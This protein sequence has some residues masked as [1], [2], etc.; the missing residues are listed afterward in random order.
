M[1]KDVKDLGFKRSSLTEEIWRIVFIG[2]SL[3][4]VLSLVSYHPLDSPRWTSTPN[5]PPHNLVKVVGAHLSDALYFYIGWGALF[6]PAILLFC[7]LRRKEG[8]SFRRELLLRGGGT[9]LL[10]L[11]LSSLLSLPGIKGPFRIEDVNIPAGGFIGLWAG[12][13]V[14]LLFG[15]FS[16][17]LCALT[18]LVGSMVAFD[19]SL[20]HLIRT[21]K[22][23]IRVSKE[24]IVGRY[25]QR[26]RDL[27]P[28]RPVPL[29]RQATKV[30]KAEGPIIE[31]A[32]EKREEPTS[33]ELPTLTLLDEPR[34]SKERKEGVLADSRLL[35]NT[36]HEFGIDAKVLQVSQGPR[37]TRFEV[38]PAPGVRVASIMGLADDIALALATPN[39][40]IET[41]IPGKSAIGIEVP[42]KRAGI[43]CLRE[44]LESPK[45]TNSD[46][47]LLIGLGKDIS[48]Q[49]V[50]IDLQEMPHLLIAGATGSG[51]SVCINSIIVSLLYRV[52]PSEAKFMLI[53]PKR[54]E[55]GIFNGIPH[56]I[57]PVINDP[58]KSTQAM[59]WL[60]E[61]MEERYKR[62]AKMGVRDIEGYNQRAK[63]TQEIEHL[64]Y[65]IMV[66]DELADLMLVAMAECE[67][68]I[69]RL[70]QMARGVGIHLILATQRPSVDII[71]GIIKANLPSRISFQVSAKVDS[72]TILDTNG[73]ER[74]LGAGDMLF[75]P[76]GA[77]RP[78]RLQGSYISLKELER[79]VE[80]VR[81]QGGP[82]QMEEGDIL[83]TREEEEETPI[84]DELYTKALKIVANLESASASMLQRRL[85]IGYNRAARIIEAMEAEGLVGP[86][87]GVKPR[88]VF[89]ERI[90]ERGI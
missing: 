37:V 16:Y 40:R 14:Y 68:A 30:E 27:E 58:K 19:L 49:P 69:T 1:G 22:E 89:V 17:P 83:P 24:R 25:L 70:S 63:E 56:L 90:R 6:L 76:A 88:E 43:V 60:V 15:V 45:F 65:I 11:S 38:Q 75:S 44:I 86:Q 55:L 36:L 80:F 67:D 82:P 78:M 29:P 18:T 35:E 64:P 2:A 85:R 34:V 48:G 54:V 62:F 28:R 3:L 23:F 51:K 59:K 12:E 5:A 77:L 81:A 73:A 50:V 32:K 74:L 20:F 33:W 41:P 87:D 71:T 4:I 7:A 10:I 42:N 21:S 9:L 13:V 8:R 57:S 39:I 26:E 47:R 61:Q 52:S 31:E 66:V 79:V 72:R 53:D 46:K 84:D